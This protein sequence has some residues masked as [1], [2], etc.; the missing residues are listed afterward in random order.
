MD[1]AENH[2]SKWLV[3]QQATTQEAFRFLDPSQEFFNIKTHHDCEK[4]FWQHEKDILD[5][6]SKAFPYPNVF[7]PRKRVF[8]PR[9]KNSV[10]VNPYIL[11]IRMGKLMGSPIFRIQ[12]HIITWLVTLYIPQC[13]SFIVPSISSLYPQTVPYTTFFESSPL[14][15]RVP[16]GL[17]S[18]TGTF[19]EK[20]IDM[21]KQHKN[22]MDVDH[23]QMKT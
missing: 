6:F 16:H 18:E 10:G 13:T 23:F 17:A 8:L 19:Q 3:F 20:N 14:R 11:A 4:R 15:L 21:E 5:H 7:K 22:T 12:S 2:R 9:P 1:Q